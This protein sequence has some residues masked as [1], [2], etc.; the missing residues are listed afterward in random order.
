MNK[1][2]LLGV[3][4][5]AMTLCLCVTPSFAEDASPSPSPSL[6]PR[7]TIRQGMKKEV[8]T[9]RQTIRTERNKIHADRLQVRFGFYA[10]RLN[11]IAA[12]IQILITKDQTAGKN[13]TKAQAQLDAGKATLTQA[14]AD[15]QQAV[16]MFNSISVATWNVQQ[17]EIKAAIAQAQKARKEFVTARQ[18]M[19]S[20]VSIL[21]TL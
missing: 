5:S 13:V 3:G 21:K 1:K 7:Q 16:S 8:A 20:A 15:G 9:I 4:L 14:I 2:M 12:R 6:T 19:V 10:D 18:S 17:P 11:N